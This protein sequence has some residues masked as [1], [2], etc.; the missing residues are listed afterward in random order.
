M[1]QMIIMTILKSI[2]LHTHYSFAMDQ[3]HMQDSKINYR[4]LLTG[5]ID[6]AKYADYI[7][8]RVKIKVKS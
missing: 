1:W 2:S 3:S 4:L 6:F 5:Q 7:I 8:Y